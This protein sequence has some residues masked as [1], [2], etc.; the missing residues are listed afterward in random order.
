MLNDDDERGVTNVFRIGSEDEDD[1]VREVITESSIIGKQ[2]FTS[3]SSAFTNL[4]QYT[5]NSSANY[6]RVLPLLMDN[7]SDN[8]VSATASLLTS[9]GERSLFNYSNLDRSLVSYNESNSTTHSTNVTDE[10]YQILGPVRDPLSTVIPMTLIYGLIFITGVLGNVCTCIVIVK[11]KYMHTTVNYYLFSLASSDLLL[12]ILGLPQEM[13]M[14]WQKYPYV[15]GET[16]CVIRALTSETSTNASILT[17]TAFTVERYMAICHP[18]RAHT[19]SSLPRAVKVILVIWA[20]SAM[21]SVPIAIQ[22]GIVFQ[23]SCI[24]LSSP[25][26]QVVIISLHLCNIVRQYLQNGTILKESA[27]C[28]LKHPLPHVFEI[29][30]VCFFVLP[31]CVISLL[32]VLIGIRLRKSASM[33]AKEEDSPEGCVAQQHHNNRFGSV[34]HGNYRQQVAS[35]RSVIKMLVVFDLAFALIACRAKIVC[36]QKLSTSRQ[37]IHHKNMSLHMH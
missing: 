5:S 19:M 33:G 20:F 22:L 2:K 16:F 29:S 25:S 24:T 15:F 17:I 7:K 13:W 23:V 30:T 8:L 18:L 1:F 28:T 34:S 11:N 32:Y 37:K 14:L 9:F 12:L 27:H 31:M 4:L 36:K 6:E 21:F 3:T 35:R 26:L 10:V